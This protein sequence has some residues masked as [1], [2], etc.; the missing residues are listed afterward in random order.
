MT[1]HIFHIL[2]IAMVAT[3]AACES[4]TYEEGD[5]SYSYMMA[6]LC[7]AQTNS[8]CS[9]DF[10]VMDDGTRKQL[11]E[12]QKTDWAERPDTAYRALIYYN[13]VETSGATGSIE[14]LSI[15]RV[16][17]VKPLR[18]INASEIAID[19][20]SLVALWKSDNGK[21]LNC[22]V[23]LK[24][25]TADADSNGQTLGVVETGVTRAADGLS[26]S[27]I[28]LLHDQGDVPEYY[29]QTMIFSLPL[30]FIDADSISFNVHT[31]EGISNHR[32]AVKAK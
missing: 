12:A 7:E 24:T 29:S 6:D 15:Q 2:A 25:G 28:T 1:R 26:C 27:H 17:V 30:A 31:A 18:G 3:L 21:F 4:R 5:S 20:V 11:T 13:N 32:F 19:P 14:L 16:P 9:V 22:R 10:V 23:N 8:D